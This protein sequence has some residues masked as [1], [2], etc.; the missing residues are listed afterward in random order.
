[1]YSLIQKRKSIAIVV[2]AAFSAL[3]I[4]SAPARATMVGTGEIFK[5]N[6]HDLSRNRIKMF[7]DRSE[8]HNHLVN[9]G[10]NPE[11]AKVRI[12]SLTDEEIEN[13]ASRMDQL[14]AGGD[15]VGALIGAALIVFI[16]LLITDILGFTHVFPFVKSHK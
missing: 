13:I 14:P 8:V 9:W 15:A 2:I 7:L 1:M 6:Q 3:S 5:Q 10:I 16:I 12:D 11:E 4:I